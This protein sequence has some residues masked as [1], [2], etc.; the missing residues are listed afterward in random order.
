[1]LALLALLAGCAEVPLQMEYSPPASAAADAVA[2]GRVWPAAPETAR[3]RL[4]GVLVG[5][6]NFRAVEQPARA[7][8]LLRWVVG[9]GP[10]GS[11]V[12]DLLVRPQSGV[13]DGAGRVYVTD[14]GRRAVFVFD[15]AAGQLRI[16][17]QADRNGLFVAPIGIVLGAR[18]ELW[19]ADSGLGRVVRL[20]PTGEAL[21]S[22]GEGVLQRPTGLARDAAANRL[23]VADSGAHD[24][25][26]FD[27]EGNLVARLG[28]HGEGPGEFN[29][30]T[31]L[32]RAGGALDGADHLDGR[33]QVL[34]LAGTPRAGSG[35]RGRYGGNFT[36]PKGV[37]VDPDGNVYVV[38]SYYDHLLVFDGAGR[39]LLPLGGT[40]S[41]MGQF[42][43][44]SGT[45]I[46]PRG[47]VFIADTFNGRVIVLQYLG[48]SA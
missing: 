41:E 5:E 13:A 28:R 38:E 46:D 11:R 48:A 10:W 20:S 42:F 16:W 45:W 32:A 4:A 26:V 31:F 35:Q 8:R 21:G 23:Y 1:M 15:E 22:I 12:P 6:S 44:P 14:V 27:D 18:E 39:F 30:P 47:R 3:Y 25:K 40:G 9:L 2:G 36:R 24:I 29:G 33:A 17:E 19:V 37:A 7:T 43:L 34:A